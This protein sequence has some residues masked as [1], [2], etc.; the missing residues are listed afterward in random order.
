MCKRRCTRKN[1]CASAKK[2]KKGLRDFSTRPLRVG[3]GNP[4]TLRR[5][6]PP[7]RAAA[8]LLLCLPCSLHLQRWSFCAALLPAPSSCSARAPCFFSSLRPARR[9]A[10]EGPSRG[11]ARVRLPRYAGR[12]RHKCP[13]S[14]ARR[15]GG[16]MRSRL[17]ARP[18][19]PP[20]PTLS[21]RECQTSSLRPARAIETVQLY[22][23]H[24]ASLV[25][26]P[27][28]GVQGGLCGS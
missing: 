11:G 25:H 4:C 15:T 5:I 28:S 19:K 7:F 17:K 22:S 6:L 10:A 8:W 27:A 18:F 24:P 9:G 20:P 2:S 14:T 16:A 1:C 12:G 3:A 26:V 21:G 13:N 23:L